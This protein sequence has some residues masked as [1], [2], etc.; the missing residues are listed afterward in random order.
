MSVD[1]GKIGTRT[2]RNWNLPFDFPAMVYQFYCSFLSRRP[3]YSTFAAV[4]YSPRFNSI[5]VMAIL[6]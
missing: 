6:F 2:E 1:L 4:I 5:Q 3:V